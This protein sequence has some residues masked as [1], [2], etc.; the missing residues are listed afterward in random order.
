MMVHLT[1][2]DGVTV[3]E[4]ASRPN[5]SDIRTLEAFILAIVRSAVLA[6]QP[7]TTVKASRSASYR[8]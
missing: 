3:D 6:E 1:V 5:P 2:S 7:R 8:S 4:M